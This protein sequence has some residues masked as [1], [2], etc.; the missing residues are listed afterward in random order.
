VRE[1]LRNA[2][3]LDDGKPCEPSDDERAVLDRVV[4]EVVRRRLSTPA[5]AFLEMSRPL[6]VVGAAAIHF[7]TPIAAVL[8][9]PLQLRRFADFLERRGSVDYLCRMIERAEQ[10]R[11]G[12]CCEG[13]EPPR[14]KVDSGVPDADPSSASTRSGVG[15]GHG[16]SDGESNHE[17]QSGGHEAGPAES[18]PIRSTSAPTGRDDN[19]PR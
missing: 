19:A 6:N 7:F 10:A 4:D 3:A 15:G 8:A 5:I 18:A 14:E 11:L 9:N 16:G 1:F 12:A 17:P 13:A 2:F